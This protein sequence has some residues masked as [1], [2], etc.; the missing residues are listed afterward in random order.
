MGIPADAFAYEFGASV[1][2]N[3]SSVTLRIQIYPRWGTASIYPAVDAA[4]PIHCDGPLRRL[5]IGYGTGTIYVEKQDA[6]EVV[7]TVESW[8]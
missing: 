8:N 4:Y 6:T 2:R 5:T 3:A 7:V 1:P